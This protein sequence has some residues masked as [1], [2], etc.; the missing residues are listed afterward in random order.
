MILR[1]TKERLLLV[2]SG[3]LDRQGLEREERLVLFAYTYEM[4]VPKTKEE[5]EKEKGEGKKKKMKSSPS[6][7]YAMISHPLREHAPEGAKEK[8]KEVEKK[9]NTKKFNFQG[10]DQE[11]LLDYSYW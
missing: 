6:Q 7:L 10:Q 11:I 3:G 5:S 8:E 2:V 9:G 1:L 4:K